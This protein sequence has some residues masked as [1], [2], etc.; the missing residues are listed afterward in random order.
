MLP[1]QI[2]GQIVVFRILQIEF[3]FGSGDYEQGKI[4]MMCPWCK[5]KGGT[6]LTR[7]FG[8]GA[9]PLF[10]HD[11]IWINRSG[12]IYFGASW[13]EWKSSSLAKILS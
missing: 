2:V 6:F 10:K 11:C 3:M 4:Y 7:K 5:G 8:T 12:K 1:G 13:I 9:M